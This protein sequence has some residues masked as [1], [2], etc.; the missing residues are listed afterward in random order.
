MNRRQQENVWPVE[1]PA[2]PEATQG[3][4]VGR[5]GI[6]EGC[7]ETG[8]EAPSTILLFQINKSFALGEKLINTVDLPCI[9]RPGNLFARGIT[10]NSLG[11]QHFLYKYRAKAR[12][13]FA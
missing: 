2:S 11:F 8:P 6:K 5:P 1:S 10:V 12:T 9:S 4:T 13:G 3:E 7:I